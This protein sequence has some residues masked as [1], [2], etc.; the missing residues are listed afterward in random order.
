RWKRE[1]YPEN[2][3]EYIDIEEY[4]DVSFLSHL[5]YMT[6][7]LFTL[8]SVLTMMADIGIVT[9]LIV[10]N[11]FQ[12]ALDN[13]CPSGAAGLNICGPQ[14]S[15]MSFIQIRYRPWIILGCVCL[16]FILLGLD[17]RKANAI[18]KSGDISFS[19]TSPIAYRYYCLRSYAHYCFFR[20]VQNSKKVVDVLAFYCFFAFKG[21]KRLILAEFPRQF[22]NFGNIV[23]LIQI[24]SNA[25]AA[26][27][28]IITGQRQAGPA[29]S[30]NPLPSSLQTV[31]FILSCITVGIWIVGFL[32][33][34]LAIFVYIPLYGVIQGN[35]KEYCCHKID[36][37]IHELLSKR[38]RKRAEESRKAGLLEIEQ[39]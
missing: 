21:W 16:S 27:N 14:P 34:L 12:Q 3:F 23:N 2:K 36:K 5:R 9:I 25:I 28:T 10:N 4:V 22:L 32:S 24:Y 38:S 33:L 8:K 18:I 31:S 29:G 6:V 35:L 7:F 1:V 13:S 15:F 37:R 30:A 20:Q 11:V 39:N 19:F 26:N 17:W